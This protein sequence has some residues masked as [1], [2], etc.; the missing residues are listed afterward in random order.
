MT[1]DIARHL[2]SYLASKGVKMHSIVCDF[3]ESSDG[4]TYFLQV[5]DCDFSL[6]K[7]QLSKKGSLA[8][9]NSAG[10]VGWKEDGTKEGAFACGARLLCD[11]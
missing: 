2:N 9:L 4:N 6:E 10:R 1:K 5:K 7:Q 3:L 11:N 8:Q